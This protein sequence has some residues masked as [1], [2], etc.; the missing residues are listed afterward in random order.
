VRYVGHLDEGERSAN[1]SL[2]VGREYVV[3][4][5]L[6]SSATGT[7]LMLLDEETQ[8]PA[9]YPAPGFDLTSDEVPS[10]WRIR[11]GGETGNAGNVKVAPAA[12]LEAGFLEDYWGDGG[13]ATVSARA[14][15]ERELEVILRE[16][17]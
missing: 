13:Q 17:V 12:W 7:S 3:L 8:E 10:N 11:V 16:S 6:C 15:F 4:S 9:W 14:A 5:I 2:V 1:R